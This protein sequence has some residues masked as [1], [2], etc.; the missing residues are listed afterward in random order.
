[1]SEELA[2]TE[3]HGVLLRHFFAASSG[4]DERYLTKVEIDAARELEFIG[5]V[6][7][8]SDGRLLANYGNRALIEYMRKLTGDSTPM[9]PAASSADIEQMRTEEQTINALLR[10]IQELTTVILR[11]PTPEDLFRSAL[12]HLRGNVVFDVGLVVMLEQSLELYIARDE[13]SADIY[14][15]GLVRRVKSIVDLEV[16]TAFRAADTLLKCEN[17]DLPHRAG[18]V[19]PLAFCTHTLLRQDSRTAGL[20]VLFRSDQAFTSE[21]QQMLRVLAGQVAMVLGMIQAR[22]QIQNLADTDD[23]TGIPN[24]RVFR[25]RLISEVERANAYS[26]PLSLLMF[27]VDR[28]KS[29]NDTYGHTIGDVVLS[30]ICGAVKSGLRGPDLFARIGGDEFAVLL[31]HTDLTG[32]IGAARHLIDRVRAHEFPN[33]EIRPTVSVG[34]AS[35]ME[36]MTPGD[37]Q[38]AADD[39]LYEAKRSGRDRFSY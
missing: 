19:S 12:G 9:P 27:D 26:V 18:S 32:A 35:L 10:Y 39:K 6:T 23:L 30:E 13:A 15:E 5:F 7:R 8:T 28:F 31:P 37:L 4:L 34:V 25:Q 11:S 17:A 1:M 33:L 38:K 24:K 16:P 14:N 3:R 36:S 21:E 20:F 2:L 29:I 22:Q